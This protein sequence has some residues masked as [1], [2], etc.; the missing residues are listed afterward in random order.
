[1]VSM[2]GPSRGMDILLKKNYILPTVDSLL[3]P[4]RIKDLR[5][6]P[7]M[8][9]ARKRH[10]GITKNLFLMELKFVASSPCPLFLTMNQYLYQKV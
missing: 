1:M 6:A 5:V 4:F 7:N 10:Q 2:T 9:C 3:Y 8:V